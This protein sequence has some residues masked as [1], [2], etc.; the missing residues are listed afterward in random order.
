MRTSGGC[1]LVRPWEA[2][3]V[4]ISGALLVILATDMFEKLHIDDPVG[5]LSVHGIGGIWVS[6]ISRMD[7]EFFSNTFDFL[8][9]AHHGSH[10][11]IFM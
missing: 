6:N 2:I 7:S 8:T 11:L 3:L 10:Y 5:A 4:G 9:E 1:A